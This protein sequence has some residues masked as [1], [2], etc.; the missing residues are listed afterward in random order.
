MTKSVSYTTARGAEVT[1]TLV[2]E[3][4]ESINLDGDVSEIVRPCWD[5]VYTLNGKTV[6]AKRID[7]P[8]SGPAIEIDMGS[9]T[10][11]RTRVIQSAV[12]AIPAD[13][14]AEVDALIAEHEDEAR[15]RIRRDMAEAKAYDA[16]ARK[17]ATDGGAA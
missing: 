3:R 2:T 6:T 17:I 15:A 13:K 5:L 11:G 4:V 12:A 7:H 16:R 10:E 8:A 1:L 9:R 14:L